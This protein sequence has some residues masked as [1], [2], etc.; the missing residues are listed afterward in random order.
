MTQVSRM[1]NLLVGPSAGGGRVLAAVALGL[2]LAGCGSATVSGRREV[3][4]TPTAPP[5]VV[6]VTDFELDA[7]QIQAEKS[8]L[9]PPPAPPG[10]LGAV[11]PQRP[12]TRTDPEKRARE[13]VELMSTSL[14]EKLEKAGLTV[15]RLGAKDPRPTSGWLLRGM[16]TEVDEGNRVRRAIIG[17]GAGKTQMALVIAV[18]DLA[19][20]VPQ[21]LYEIDTKADSGKAPGAGPM[22]VLHPA[23]GAARFVLAGNDL[24]RNVKQAAAEIASDLAAR[25]QR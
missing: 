11:L 25:V 1:S 9:P 5:A 21:P 2:V 13:L 19:R 8:L 6:H 22:I 12:R 15:R 3:G 23:V 14:V 16:F 7:Q 20:G 4:L 24:D 18:D 17:F 10:P